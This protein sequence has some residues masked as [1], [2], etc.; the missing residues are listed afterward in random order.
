MVAFNDIFKL[1]LDRTGDWVSITPSDDEVAD[2]R[3]LLEA[4][5]IKTYEAFPWAWRLEISSPKIEKITD[6]DGRDLFFIPFPEGEIL[7][8]KD[9]NPILSEGSSIMWLSSFVGDKIY[10]PERKKVWIVINPPAR[11]SFAADNLP[12]REELVE[13][14]VNFTLADKLE[15][16]GQHAKASQKYALANE[17]LSLVIARNA[18]C[19][20]AK[21]IVTKR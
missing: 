6:E 17:L 4:R 20:N 13:S 5:I 10:I 7:D 15:Q 21:L 1:F 16:D 12:I 18:P 9:G 11:A 2:L 8:I 19:N 3:A 14:I